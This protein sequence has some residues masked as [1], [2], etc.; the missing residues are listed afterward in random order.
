MKNIIFTFYSTSFAQI[1]LVKVRRIRQK[2]TFFQIQMHCCASCCCL[3]KNVC[4]TKK[5]CT[6]TDFLTPSLTLTNTSN[7]F[8]CVF[9]SIFFSPSSIYFV[10]FHSWGVQT[11]SVKISLTWDENLWRNHI[12]KLTTFGQFFQLPH[13]AL[14]HWSIG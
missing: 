7:K 5:N 13:S 6:K 14:V 2:N 8:F 3:L 10:F 12:P 4:F 11:A 9:F 1:S